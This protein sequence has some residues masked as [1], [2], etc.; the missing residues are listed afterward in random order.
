MKPE[1]GYRLLPDRFEG[2]KWTYKIQGPFRI[3]GEAEGYCMCRFPGAA[4][5]VISRKK[6]VDSEGKQP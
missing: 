3:M 4:P 1:Q 6:I 5:F 2:K